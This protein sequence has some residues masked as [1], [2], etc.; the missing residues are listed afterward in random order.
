[1]INIENIP[2]LLR[3]AAVFALVLVAIYK[4]ISLGNAF[5]MGAIVLGIFFSQSVFNVL[6]SILHSVYEPKTLALTIIVSLI[7]ILSSSM[8]AAGQMQRMLKSFRGLLT[9]PRLNLILFPALI[10]LLPMPGGAVF[11]APMVKELAADAHIEPAKLSFINYWFRHIWEYWWPMYPGVLLGT[12]MADLNLLVF[13]IYL[14]PLTA[15]ALYFGGRPLRGVFNPGSAGKY[16]DKPPL[17]PF[18]IELMPI[19]M[20][21][22]PGISLGLVFTRLW[23]QLTI[24]KEAGLMVALI[25]AILWIW[26]VNRFSTGRIKKIVANL[27][28]AKMA[29]LIIAILMFKSVLT[30]SQAIVAIGDEL[31][32][33]NVPLFLIAMFLPFIVGMITGITIAF[34]G[35]AFPILIPL[36]YAHAQ[37][38]FML[39]Y[40]ML[41]LVCGFAGVLLSPLHLCLILSNQ[42]FKAQTGD[43]YR[44]LWRPSL[45][46][47]VLSVAYFWLLK[48]LG[49][50]A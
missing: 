31:T 5:L 8:E 10:G 20:V 19:V 12:L 11:S 3:V 38:P 27:Q 32:Q 48:L 23:P 47:V 28:T 7:L 16:R 44:L 29:Y 24:T 25:A 36:I 50:I 13:I 1:M 43:L 33:L 21:I 9:S 40:I 14:C 46:L 41:A 35:S 30:D 45:Y 39:A 17:K 26:R 18:L 22:V 37:E 42:Y 34:V 49:P 4:K 15:A 6:S 2:A